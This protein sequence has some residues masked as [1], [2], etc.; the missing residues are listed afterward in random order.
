MP[1]A[2]NLI[3]PRFADGRHEAVSEGLRRNGYQAIDGTEVPA[4]KR[5]DVVCTWNL[6]T[7]H[8][9]KAHLRAKAAA[10]PTLVFEEAYTRR[11]WPMKHFAVGIDGH[12]GAGRWPDGGP[13]RWESLHIRLKPW[14][15][16]GD[17]ILVC[18]AR[19]M[20]AP[21]TR[22]PKGWADG[23][24]RRLQQVTD[25]RIHLRRHPGKGTAQRPLDLDLANAWAVVVW[26]S[27]CA[28]HALVEGIPV[29]F[30]GPQIAVESACERDIGKINNPRLSDRRPTFQR[31]AWGQ[32]GVDEIRSGDAFRHL[33]RPDR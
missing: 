8:A 27:N 25:R 2:Y 18:A 14:R 15:L 33:L 19:G 5:G 4:P 12:N 3:P 24:C 13:E 23:V 11:L 30:E 29:F 6:H 20:G 22:E 32:W 7:A 17:H 1:T 28:T 9:Y 10:C 21:E 16:A 26:G 31:L